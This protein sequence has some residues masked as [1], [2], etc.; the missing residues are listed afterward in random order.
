MAADVFVADEQSSLAVDVAR[1][2]SLARRV[3]EAEGVRDDIEVSLLFVDEPT[4]AELHERFLG[5][6]GPTDVLAFPIDEEPA[7]GGRSPDEGGTGPGGPV[8]SEE[9]EVP[10]ILGDVVVCPTVAVRNA[11]EHGVSVEDEVALLVVHGLLH[12]L[13]MDHVE[14]ADA[15]RMEQRE[16][17]LLAR[18]HREPL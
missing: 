18:F 8:A 5:K 12:L 3:L 7:A 4:I 13:G 9:D 6:S 11:S 10:V 16:R 15:E 17:E 14:D 2:A 1:W